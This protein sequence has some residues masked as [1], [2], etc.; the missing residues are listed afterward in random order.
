M[1]QLKTETAVGLFVLAA[2]GALIYLSFQIGS[3]HLLRK[4]INII[5]FSCI[6]TISLA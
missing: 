4:R 6:V 1:A 5:N 3:L 2:L